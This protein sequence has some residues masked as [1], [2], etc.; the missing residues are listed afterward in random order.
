MILKKNPHINQKE[1]DAFVELGEQ[2][3]KNG[4]RPR[5]YQLQQPSEKELRLVD[6]EKMDPRTVH[7]SA[8]RD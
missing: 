8:I 3:R 1:L 6:E 5:G 4:F 2:L 7:I